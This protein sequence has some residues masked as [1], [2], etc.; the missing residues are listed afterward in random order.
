MLRSVSLAASAYRL[1]AVRRA[2]LEAQQQPDEL[3]VQGVATGRTTVAAE[4]LVGQRRV[5]SPPVPLV[6]LENIV[7]VPA[8]IYV[9][10]MAHLQPELKVL[11]G[12]RPI[13]D[14]AAVQLP[15]PHFQW[16]AQSLEGGVACFMSIAF[17]QIVMKSCVSYAYLDG[18]MTSSL[19]PGGRDVLHVHPELGRVVTQRLGSGRVLAVDSRISNH[20]AQALLHVV[21]PVA[22]RFRTQPLWRSGG[23]STAQGAPGWAGH[24]EAGWGEEELRLLRGP[25]LGVLSDEKVLQLV[26]GRSYALR[27]ELLEK[28]QQEMQIPLNLRA[29]SRCEAG[30]A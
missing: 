15:V 8:L 1:S 16:Q 24:M 6:V 4:L 9:P 22:L 7:L 10:P 12:Q 25:A 28:S 11:R 20:S 17:M 19:L 14:L 3:L 13:E 30:Q 21:D 23:A 27:L 29:R 2:L 26:Q 5:V 18:F